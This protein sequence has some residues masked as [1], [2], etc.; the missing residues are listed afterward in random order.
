GLAAEAA[1]LDK[2]DAAAQRTRRTVAAAIAAL[3]AL[4][5]RLQAADRQRVEAVALLAEDDVLTE[6][7]LQADTAAGGA[8]A[9]VRTA[10]DDIRTRT[11]LCSTLRAERASVGYVEP[12]TTTASLDQTRE[13][14]RIADPFVSTPGFEHAEDARRKAEEVRSSLRLGLGP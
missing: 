13:A 11:S 6:R 9:T 4:L 8:L 12:A 7:I 3:T 2:A 10:D 5:P 14:W 1:E